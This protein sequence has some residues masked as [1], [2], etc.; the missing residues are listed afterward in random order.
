[1]KNKIN[2]EYSGIESYVWDSFKKNNTDWIPQ[3]IALSFQG[4]EKLEETQIAEA[5]ATAQEQMKN[6]QQEIKSIK[7]MR[8]TED[9]KYFSI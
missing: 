4:K 2:T 9:S 7:S 6:L 8:L 1:M 3:Q 5:I